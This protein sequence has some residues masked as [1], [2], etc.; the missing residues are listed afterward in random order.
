MPVMNS[1]FETT[2]DA[3]VRNPWDPERVPGASSAG[4]AAAVAAGILPAA[5]G[6][7][8]A[9]SSRLPPDYTGVVGMHPTAGLVP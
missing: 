3:L 7:D 8:G 5:F 2:G 4:S 9:G 6:S 1:Q